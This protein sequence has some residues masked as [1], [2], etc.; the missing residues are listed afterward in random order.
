MTDSR[1]GNIKAL[2]KLFHNSSLSRNAKE[3]ELSTLREISILQK[4]SH[5]NVI[6]LEEVIVGQDR[7]EIYLLLEYCEFSL[8]S[9]IYESGQLLRE[10]TRKYF[11]LALLKGLAHIHSQAIIHRDIKP[12]NLLISSS[13]V[14]KIADFGLARLCSVK[15]A[16]CK[17]T[18]S[19]VTLAYRA[20]EILFGADYSFPVDMWS[21]GCVFGE[22]TIRR[23]LFSPKEG[24]LSQI[25]EIMKVLGAPTREKCPAL[26]EIEDRFTVDS[27]QQ[28]IFNT[29]FDGRS[30]ECLKLLRSLLDYD[31]NKRI[32][33]QDAVKHRYFEEDPLP[34]LEEPW[35]PK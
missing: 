26:R 10:V 25:K 12:S 4:L 30:A 1:D 27:N 17:L 34:A 8:Y 11:I 14:L 29:L 19:S 22:L 5:E 6:T 18:P 20:P 7:H 28:G 16:S 32:N 24:D 31:A 15:S 21:A 23:P 35:A 2:K 13:G 3:L 33:S 9:L